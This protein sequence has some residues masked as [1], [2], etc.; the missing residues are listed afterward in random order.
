MSN[1]AHTPTPWEVDE[2]GIQVD[3]ANGSATSIAFCAGTRPGK[4]WSGT[5]YA[6]KRHQQANAAFIVRA[7]NAHEQLVAALRGLIKLVDENGLCMDE[8][9]T[10]EAAIDALA[11]AED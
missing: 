10:Y 3:A 11:A 2:S 7:C 4:N 8:C 9:A 6:T 5:D 1:A